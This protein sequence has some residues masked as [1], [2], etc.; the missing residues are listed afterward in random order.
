MKYKLINEYYRPKIFHTAGLYQHYDEAKKKI[1]YKIDDG[2]QFNQDVFRNTIEKSEEIFKSNYVINNLLLNLS[3]NFR[4]IKEQVIYHIEGGYLAVFFI[5]I[6][7]IILT[8]VYYTARWFNSRKKIYMKFFGHLQWIFSLFIVFVLCCVMVGVYFL[9]SLSISLNE[10]LTLLKNNETFVNQK[11]TFRCF[12]NRQS[13]IEIP[14]HPYNYIFNELDE[15]YNSLL[16]LTFIEESDFYEYREFLNTIED[17]ISLINNPDYLFL[18]QESN[19]TLRYALKESN[20]YFDN[21]I[22]Y[23]SINPLQLLLNC[24]N[25]IALEIMYET[26]ACQVPLTPYNKYDKLENSYCYEFK[27]VTLEEF[28]S[29]IKKYDFDT[30]CNNISYQNEIF[31]IDEIALKRFTQLKDLYEKYEE[32]FIHFYDN[33]L[34]K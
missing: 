23:K 26:S 16:Q 14:T 10:G 8:F 12:N 2:K 27:N 4:L 32:F 28:S 5:Q 34:T 22:N 9:G 21:I 19:T 25:P 1:L 6:W 20:D 29:I 18:K 33:V 15:M 13:K 3:Y 31:R 11:E 24:S 7:I 17:Y 30:K